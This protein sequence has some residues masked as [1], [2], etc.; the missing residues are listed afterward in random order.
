M[1]ILGRGGTDGADGRMWREGRREM[2]EFREAPQAFSQ[3]LGFLLFD[4]CFLFIHLFIATF[5]LR[6]FR[7]LL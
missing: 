2:G 7:G 1:S 3:L 4:V 5:I 6:L